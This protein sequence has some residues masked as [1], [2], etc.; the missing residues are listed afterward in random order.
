M[1]LLRTQLGVESPGTDFVI[2]LQ[3]TVSR[4]RDGDGY[5]PIDLQLCA[6]TGQQMNRDGRNGTQL[7]P[8]VCPCRLEKNKAKTEL[9]PTGSGN[10][11]HMA[12]NYK[13]SDERRVLR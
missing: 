4:Q 9:N 7:E 8:L 11:Q 3:V 2:L 13:N 5:R 12:G 10:A 1:L 6:I